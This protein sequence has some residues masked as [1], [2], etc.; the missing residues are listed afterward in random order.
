MPLSTDVSLPR[1][2]EAVFP[3]RCVGCLSDRPELVTFHGSRFTWGRVF[4]FWLWLLRKRVRCEVPICSD[5][6]P[7]VRRRKFVELLL[8]VG[9]ASGVVVTIYPWLQTLDLGRQ[10]SK[11]IALA[12][13]LV[14]WLP[15][16]VWSIFR[17]PLFDLTVG[18]DLVDYEF[19]NADYAERFV[20]ANEDQVVD[21]G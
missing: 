1:D 21:V 6:R 17:P 15:Y 9:V 3:P 19:A 11:L 7:A 14:G 20:E 4:F 13:V 18:E 5:C 12:A 2:A 16:I 8:L 10:G